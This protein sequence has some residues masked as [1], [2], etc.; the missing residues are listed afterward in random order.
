MKK[1]YER[2]QIVHVETMT[3]GAVRCVR[4]NTMSCPGGPITS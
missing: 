1:P 4:Q 3:T 2:P